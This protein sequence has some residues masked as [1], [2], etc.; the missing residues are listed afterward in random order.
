ML[1]Y[2]RVLSIYVPVDGIYP[3][4]SAD[5]ST[6]KSYDFAKNR[7]IIFQQKS[8]DNDAVFLEGTEF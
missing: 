2:K 7:N 5:V 1:P 4:Y 3:Y 6:K 8:I